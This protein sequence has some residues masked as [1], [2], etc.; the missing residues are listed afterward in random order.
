M[1]KRRI[2]VKILD[3]NTEA[4]TTRIVI[5]VFSCR[6]TF[7]RIIGAID[8]RD[9]ADTLQLMFKRRII[10]KILDKN[11]PCRVP[12]TEAAGVITMPCPSN[13]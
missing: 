2:I 11:N 7:D 12:G 10:V 3:K 5:P 13:G 8:Y 4:S 6:D 1:F 9:I